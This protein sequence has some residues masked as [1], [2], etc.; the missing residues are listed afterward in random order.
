MIHS[1][2]HFNLKMKGIKR[3]SS[4]VRQL[5]LVL[6]VIGSIPARVKE[7]FGVRTRR[8]LVSYAGKT[9]DIKCIVLWIWTLTGCPLYRESHP[10]CWLKNPTVISIWLIVGFYPATRSVQSTPANYTRKRVWKYIKKE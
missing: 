5:P 3:G 10:L 7:K 2:K 6:E 1:Y 9:L 8:S 4:V